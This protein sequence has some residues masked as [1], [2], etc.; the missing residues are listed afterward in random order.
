M[1]RIEGAE[2]FEFEIGRVRPVKL[3]FW[4]TVLLAVRKCKTN[5]VVPGYALHPAPKE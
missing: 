2:G 1:L 4:E 3:F 5:V